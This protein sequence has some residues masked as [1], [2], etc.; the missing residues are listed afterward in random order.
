MA[1][2]LY[3][4]GFWISPYVFT[5]AVALREKG[6][7]FTTAEVKLHVRAQ[8]EPSYAS[9]TLTAR[10]PA[11]THDGFTVAE[12][13]AIVEYLEDVFPE[14]R[15]LPADP[16]ERAR[17]R[18]IMSWIRS[19]DTLP[20]REER[21]THTMFYDRATAPLGAKARAAASK[22]FSV[23]G[24]VLA[25]DQAQMFAR[26]CI[27]DAD[28]AF[29]LQRLILN[30]DD[31]PAPLRAFADAEWQRPSVRAFVE[32]KRAPYVPYG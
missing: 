6:L 9:S 29:M 10:V 16:K 2:T 32:Q 14:P 24:R 18:Q 21:S 20:I 13:S 19:D 8:E 23:A 25:H 5:C 31:V 26:W 12:S 30:G 7:D 17:A 27:A 11:L 4:D 28:L 22:L 15:V 3:H 1:L